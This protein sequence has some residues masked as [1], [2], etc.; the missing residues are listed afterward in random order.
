MSA[1]LRAAILDAADAVEAA[2]EALC[3]LDAASGDGDHGVTMTIGARRVRSQL[4]GVLTDDPEALVRAAAIGMAG[5]GGAIGAIYGRGLLAIAARLR[6]GATDGDFDAARLELLA[7]AVERAATA[8][9]GLGASPGDKTIVDAL[10]PTAAALDDAARA[11]RSWSAGLA[12][13]DAA[14]QAGAAVDGRARGTNRPLRALRREEQGHGRPRR[15]FARD[16]RPRARRR[17]RSTRRRADVAALIGTSWKMNLT[18]GEADHWL[19]TFRPLAADFPGVDFFVLPP[20]TA[21]ALARERLAGSGIAWGAQDVS[22]FAN[23]A[24]TG[25]ISAAMLA[26][27]GCRYVEVGH[28]ERRRDHGEAPA[29]IAAKV[30]AILEAGMDVVLCTGELDEARSRAR[31]RRSWPTSSGAWTASAPRTWAGSSSPTSRSGQSAWAAGRHHPIASAGSTGRSPSGSAAAGANQA[32]DHLRRQR[33]RDR[34][35]PGLLAE[36]GVDGLFI[37]RNGLDPLGFAAIARAVPAP[38]QAVIR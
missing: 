34:A 16:H 18:L 4:E 22:P 5:A 9:A 14:A 21:L 30:R 2:R 29:T 25:D 11:G 15:G 13:A 17:A 33:R 38:E 26:D 10:V 31:S 7:S 20:F 8:T 36:P 37:G 3:L 19:S 32:E 28:A 6:E 27:L 1:T 23:G 12:A 35:P 24:H